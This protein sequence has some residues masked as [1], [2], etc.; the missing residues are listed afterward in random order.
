MYNTL[1]TQMLNTI[2]I[3][4]IGTEYL[5]YNSVINKIDILK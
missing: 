5:Q 3:I 2:G 1:N 4:K